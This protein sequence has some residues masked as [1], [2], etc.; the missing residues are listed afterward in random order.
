MILLTK[1]FHIFRNKH[2][3]TQIRTDSNNI[4]D[5]IL[6]TYITDFRFDMKLAF[7]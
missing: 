3:T 5:S 7:F 2:S 1:Y 6:Y 4:S